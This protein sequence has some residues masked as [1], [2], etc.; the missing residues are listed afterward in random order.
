MTRRSSICLLLPAMLAVLVSGCTDSVDTGDAD[1]PRVVQP[2]AP[3]ESGR[4]LTAEE[5]EELD[6]QP[7][8][9]IQLDVAFMQGMIIHHGQALEMTSLVPKR[10]ALK[11]L[12]LFAE[13][14]EI[15]QR[16]EIAV[17][18]SWL[19]ARGEEVPDIE[20]AQ[21]HHA[22]GEGMPGML[23]DAELAE[24]RAA[25]GHEFDRLFLSF[26]QRHHEGAL[27]MVSELFDAGGGEEPEVFQF[28][29]HV[30]ADQR[31]ELG[32]IAVMLA[33]VNGTG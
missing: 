3:G 2:G 22:H 7:P 1:A 8:T 14:M 26:M 12:S 30:D 16:D 6:I 11:D 9:Y 23:T 24:L 28:A 33:E 31:I 13:R 15:S 4:E 27:Q 21:T 5:V 25:S 19:T 29:N 10:S 17:M 20:A 18:T 32:R